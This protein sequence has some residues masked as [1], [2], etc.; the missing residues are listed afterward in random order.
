MTLSLSFSGSINVGGYVPLISNISCIQETNESNNPNIEVLLATCIISNNTEVFG[1][2]FKFGFGTE[3][4]NLRI[5]GGEGIL[6]LD[7]VPP[8]EL[9]TVTDEYNWTP[10]TQRSATLDYIIRFYGK[11]N[12]RVNNIIQY[13][14]M[15]N[16]F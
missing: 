8:D 6:G 9:I 3:I 5:Q 12:G 11:L 10:N 1:V 2:N 4:S 14:S 15:N 13:A 7:I 16:T